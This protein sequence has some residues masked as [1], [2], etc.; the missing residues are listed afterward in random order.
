MTFSEWVIVI[1]AFLGPLC[2]V[3]VANQLT[4][5][6]GRRRD[7][8]ITL[9]SLSQAMNLMFYKSIGIRSSGRLHTSLMAEVI[10]KSHEATV[11]QVE[12]AQKE[13]EA[14]N[15]GHDELTELAALVSTE[16]LALEL[17]CGSKAKSCQ[18]AI[19]RFTTAALRSVGRNSLAEDSADWV[20]AEKLLYESRNE[21]GKL[22]KK[23]GDFDSD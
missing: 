6:E 15:A 20:E 12:S 13:L 22:W 5:K 18:T 23:L 19:Q 11:S 4:N 8:A 1:S 14:Y 2:G 17:I 10:S 21:I 3:L 7:A 9:R 16:L